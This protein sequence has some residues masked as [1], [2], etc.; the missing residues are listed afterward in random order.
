M[1][2][3]TKLFHLR[4][5][6]FCKLYNTLSKLVITLLL[7]DIVKPAVPFQKPNILCYSIHIIPNG[8]KIIFFLMEI[9]FS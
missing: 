6:S 3:Q 7:F 5:Q 1:K 9:Y 8:F 4:H 2:I